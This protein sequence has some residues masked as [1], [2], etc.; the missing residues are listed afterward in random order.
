M[1]NKDY[2]FRKTLLK[3]TIAGVEV[4]LSLGLFAATDN[5]FAVLAGPVL[6]A[7]RNWIK[8]R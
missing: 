4:F 5:W 3:F 1:T 7:F 6:E 2:S 8:N